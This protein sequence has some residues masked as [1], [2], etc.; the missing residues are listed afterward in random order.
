MTA[1]IDKA[2]LAFHCIIMGVAFIGPMICLCLVI[3]ALIF[4]AAGLMR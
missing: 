2:V 1:W 4:Q 3:A